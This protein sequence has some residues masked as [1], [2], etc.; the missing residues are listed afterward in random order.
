VKYLKLQ[1]GL[2]HGLGRQGGAE[3]IGVWQYGAE[4]FAAIACDE[5]TRTTQRS[6]QRTGDALEAIVPS[7]VAVKVIERFETIHI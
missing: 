4:F 7:L 2:T 1:Y 5:L 6:L 3:G